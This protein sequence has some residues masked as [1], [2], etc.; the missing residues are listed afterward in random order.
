MIGGDVLNNDAGTACALGVFGRSNH[1]GGA[2][3][4]GLH[5][6]QGLHS[7]VIDA[8]AEH[9]QT[10][11]PV[12]FCGDLGAEVC[13]KLRTDTAPLFDALRAQP[14]DGS[15]YVLGHGRVVH[16][17]AAA[18]VTTKVDGDGAQSA[19]ADAVRNKRPVFSSALI[20]VHQDDPPLGSGDHCGV[21]LQRSSVRSLEGNTGSKSI[22]GDAGEKE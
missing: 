17:S 15:L 22:T 19:A 6:P 1:Q 5:R 14:V 7:F 20:H 4:V 16:A 8:W 2:L 10:I 21:R 12:I 11:E 9:G 13:A 18:T 3:T